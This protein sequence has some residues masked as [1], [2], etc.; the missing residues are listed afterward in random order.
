MVALPAALTT[1]YSVPARTVT[2]GAGLFP[3]P[4]PWYASGYCRIGKK[5]DHTGRVMR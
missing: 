1:A 4:P 2:A 3:A 5:S